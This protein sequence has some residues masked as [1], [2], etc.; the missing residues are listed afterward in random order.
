LH[1]DKPGIWDDSKA[2]LTYG[3]IKVGCS[4]EAIANS[5]ERAS[6]KENTSGEGDEAH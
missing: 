2:L 4:P 3:L 6:E 1:T 5:S